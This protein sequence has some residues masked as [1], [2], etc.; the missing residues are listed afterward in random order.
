M[1]REFSRTERV[2]QQLHK[3][4]AM[5]LQHE[6]KQRY[7]DIGMITVSEVEVSRDLSH[8]KVFVSFYLDNEEKNNR[9]FKTLKDGA[10]FV[11]SLL[12]KRIKMRAVPSIHFQRDNSMRDGARIGA[13]VDQAISDDIKKQQK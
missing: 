4:V 8:A 2:N 13:L 3:E 5:I 1:A 7:P 12:A 10:G 9:D 6:F 11:R